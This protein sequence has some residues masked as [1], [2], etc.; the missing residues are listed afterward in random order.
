MNT[1]RLSVVTPSRN[2][3]HA[4]GARRSCRYARTA[5]HIDSVNSAV[6]QTSVMTSAPKY[7]I[8]GKSAVTAAAATASDSDTNARAIAY[9]SRQ[10][11]TNRTVCASATGSWPAPNSR[12]R[13]ATTTGYAGVRITSGTKRGASGKRVNFPVSASTWPSRR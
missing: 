2:P 13:T 10:I 4:N 11:R 6:V 3:S 5:A 1:G 12:Y 8:G 7:G 9:V